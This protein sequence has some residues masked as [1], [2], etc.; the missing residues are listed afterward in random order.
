MRK[1]LLSFIVLMLAGSVFGVVE[2]EYYPGRQEGIYIGDLIEINLDMKLEAGF[3]YE[4]SGMD[5]MASEDY[6]IAGSG[7]LT[8]EHDEKAGINRIRKVFSIIPKKQGSVTIPP[9]RIEYWN[10]DEP[11]KKSILLTKNIE[12][13]VMSNLGQE[14]D[15]PRPITDPYRLTRSYFYLLYFLAGVII[16]ALTAYLVLRRKAKGPEI[17]VEKEPCGDIALKRLR[18]LLES[19]LLEKGHAKM[20]LF[21]LTGI[22]KQYLARA[23]EI[24][25]EDMTAREIAISLKQTSIKNELYDEITGC[26]MECDLY[27]FSEAVLNRTRAKELYDTCCDFVEKDS[28]SRKAGIIYQENKKEE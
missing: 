16:L 11:E 4:I 24:K 3:A 23:Y 8:E 12:L 21:G 27:K 22:I 2:Y 5:E 18:M 7:P 25:A 19:G 13:N 17:I 26:F 1:V 28:L 6:F 15:A 10:Q 9:M 14:D 20:F